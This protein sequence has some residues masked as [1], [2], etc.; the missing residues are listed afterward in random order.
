MTLEAFDAD[1][2]IADHD[3]F[4]MGIHFPGRMTVVRLRTGDLWL[5]SPIP[6]SEP[7]AEQL[8]A[9]GPVRYIVAPNLFH[10][11]HLQAAADRY[12][13]AHVY[14]AP[15]LSAK[16]KDVA[17]TAMLDEQAPPDWKDDLH[18]VALRAVP[19][20][21]ETVFFHRPSRTLITTDLFMN[22]HRAEGVF[23]RFVYWAEGCWKRP[24]VPR[25]IRFL[26][27]DREQMKSDL[28]T[29]VAWPTEHILMAHGEVIR[30]DA[31]RVLREGLSVFGL[32]PEAV[33]A[34]V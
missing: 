23:S 34:A 10:H 21:W 32:E 17:F 27:K 24:A 18:Q 30:E 13:D 7:L 29:I 3:M 16:R 6:I 33:S 28:R 22:V 8:A 14:G 15:G 9:I 11:M 31:A 5:H 25:L 2:W 20:F 19:A 12:P 1:L 26:V 4:A